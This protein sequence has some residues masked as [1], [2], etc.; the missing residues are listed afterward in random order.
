MSRSRTT[1]ATMLAAAIDRHLPSPPITARCSG[2]SRRQ[3]GPGTTVS[4]AGRGDGDGPLLQP[5]RLA[6]LLAQVE[7]L[8][9]P[10][11]L[12]LGRDDG[13]ARERRRVQ[14]ERALDADALGDLAHRERLAHPRAADVR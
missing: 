5:R 6:L 11:L 12:L 7:E 4:A 13:D 14:W 10:H 3:R 1:L 8:R 9:A 2:A